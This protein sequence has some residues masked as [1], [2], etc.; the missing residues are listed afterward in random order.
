MRKICVPAL[1]GGVA[2]LSGC[3]M[4]LRPSPSP[5]ALS[6]CRSTDALMASV[7]WIQPEQTVGRARLDSW[8]AGV[9]SP[10]FR[11]A[12]ASAPS[13]RVS[14]SNAGGLMIASWNVHV[15]AGDLDR[16]LAD[17]EQGA[18]TDGHRPTQLVVLL[19][20]AV[21][22]AGVPGDLP[23]GASAAARIGS[24]AWLE[25]SEIGAVA[26]RFGMS[27][28]YVPSMRN[29]AAGSG[30]TASDRGNAILSTV[31]LLDPVAIELPGERQ[32]RV[33]V[34]ARVNVRIHGAVVPFSMGSAHLDTLAGP[35]SLWVFGA[36]G[37]RSRQAASLARA[38]ADGPT[39]LGA[40]LN[41][42]MGLH[43]PAVQRLRAAFPSTP[44]EPAGKTFR[45]GL[46]LDYLFFRLPSGVL[47]QVK[48]AASRYGSD[49]FPLI[50]S[51]T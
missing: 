1:T 31:P 48:R 3:A 7:R 24:D 37:A 11:S 49:H 5:A 39:I 22:G 27:I 21:R 19:Q 47:A 4:P 12:D 15:G 8:C 20:E 34:T 6:R 43:E 46:K 29:G 17:A 18:L 23:Q 51:L 9:G 32:R 16:F 35:R 42:W 28:F 50:A 41:T 2:L 44:A 14:S 45:G 25:R 10:L 40:D 36:V 30:S 38:L 26:E 33:A 13:Q